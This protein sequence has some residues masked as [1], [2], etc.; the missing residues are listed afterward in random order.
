MTQ[1][2][3]GEDPRDTRSIPR[4]PLEWPLGWRRARHRRHSSFTMTREDRVGDGKVYKRSTA[5]NMAT[6]TERLEK[7]LDLLG[8]RNPSNAKNSL[9]PLRERCNTN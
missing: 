2:Q 1:A 7:Q 6:A 4:F 9:N 5:V 8:A 3:I